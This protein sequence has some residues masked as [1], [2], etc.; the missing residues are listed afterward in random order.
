VT[1]LTW[2]LKLYP[3]RWRRRYGQEL[4]ELIARQ[5]FSIR[6]AADLIA[7]A[8]DAWLNPRLIAAAAAAPGTMDTKGDVPMVLMIAKTMQLKCAGYGPEIGAIDKTK[9][10]AVM[11]GGT[12]VLALLYLWSV[13]QFGKNAWLL[14]LSPMAY[15]L[16]MLISL[17]WTALKGRST[18]TQAIFIGGFSIGLTAF[19]LLVEWIG[20]QI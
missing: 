16:P 1:S 5:P 4:E 17:R 6:G 14:A 13:W 20:R 18:R 8:I 12:L 7:G 19:F 9:S 11:L 3:P 15:F 10:T 2:L